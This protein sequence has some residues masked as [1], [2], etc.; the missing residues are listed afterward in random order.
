MAEPLA[1]TWPIVMQ[2]VGT[3]VEPQLAQAECD[4]TEQAGP[5]RAHSTAGQLASGEQKEGLA[6]TIW[7]SGSFLSNGS[8]VSLWSKDMALHRAEWAS[9]PQ[10]LPHS[11]SKSP[12]SAQDKPVVLHVSFQPCWRSY[13]K[14][15]WHHLQSKEQGVLVNTH[16]LILVVPILVTRVHINDAHGLPVFKDLE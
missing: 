14:V 6:R 1:K 3:H 9:R 4:Y 16:Y 10:A 15:Q 12:W 7:N 11:N 8:Y 5:Q 13:N 2:P